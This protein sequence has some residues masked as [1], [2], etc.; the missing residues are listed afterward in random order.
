MIN[1]LYNYTTRSRP[2]LF[3]RGLNSIIENSNS[4]DYHIL[5]SID[6]NDSSMYNEEMYFQLY[7]VP[8]VSIVAGES[9]SKIDAI[10]RDLNSYLESE[11]S[12]THII[13]N[14]SDDM[15]FI[16]KGFDNIIRESF[17]NY[18]QCLHFP[19][20]NRRE[21]ITM[22]ILG[23]DFYKRFNYIY[24]PEYKSFWADNEQTEVAKLLGCYKFIDKHIFNHLHPGFN[25]AE[26]DDQYK[27]DEKSNSE[28]QITYERRKAE[29][30][31]VKC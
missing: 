6:V 14:M 18:D 28:D 24:H 12:P 2:K 5:V 7:R 16:E 3:I 17:D 11:L 21:L 20:G 31:G 27:N 26:W 1:I 8:N 25:K 4:V 22:S 15:V 19:D 13:V 9:K 23:I 30:Y 29:N 10:N